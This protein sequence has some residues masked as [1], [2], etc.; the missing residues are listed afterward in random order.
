MYGTPTGGGVEGSPAEPIQLEGEPEQPQSGHASTA[1][2]PGFQ[3]TGITSDSQVTHSHE[4]GSQH[5]LCPDTKA[6]ASDTEWSAA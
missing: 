6:G 4:Q 2:Y 3:S 1:S 5:R